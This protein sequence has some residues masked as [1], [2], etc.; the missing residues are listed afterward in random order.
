[1][2]AIGS[3]LILIGFICNHDSDEAKKLDSF[4]DF[5]IGITIVGLIFLAYYFYDKNK[6]T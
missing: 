4:S 3:I 1:M 5:I 6:H 2:I